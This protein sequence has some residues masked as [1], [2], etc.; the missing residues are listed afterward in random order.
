MKIPFSKEDISIVINQL[1]NNKKAGRGGIKIEL[2]KFGTNEPAKEIAVVFNEIANT[3][4][5]QWEIVQ[6]IFAI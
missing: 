4:K 6:G 5:Y 1:K 2:I 3:R